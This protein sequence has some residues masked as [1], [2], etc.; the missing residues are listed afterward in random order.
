MNVKEFIFNTSGVEIY[1]IPNFLTPDECNH[2]CERIDQHS[3]RSEVAGAGN[4][5]T[6]YTSSRTSQSVS[7]SNS[8]PSIQPINTRIADEVGYPL[9]HGET[10]QGHVYQ[11]GQEFKDHNDFFVGDGFINHCLAS[12]QR[13]WT[14]MV[15]LNDVAAGGHTEFPEI[16]RSFA[17][18]KGTAV[19][20]KN[21]DG[22]GTEN[23]ATL[24]CGAPVLKGKKYIITKWF[25]ERIYSPSKDA[26]LAKEHH[27]GNS[28]QKKESTQNTSNELEAYVFDKKNNKVKIEYKDGIPNAMYQS[29]LD[30][31]PITKEGFAKMPIPKSLFYRILAFYHEGL[32]HS[33]PEFDPKNN[34][35]LRDFIS[36]QESYYPT[37]MIWLTDEMKTI[38]F[39]GLEDILINWANKQLLKTHCYGI[40]SYKRG[41]QLKKH[42]DG[43]Q[44]RIVSAILNIDQKVDEPWALQIDDHEGKEHEVYLEAG[45]MVLYESAVL[46]HG[47]VKPFKGD[48]FTNLFVHYIH[49]EE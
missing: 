34:D 23:A 4:Q 28:I 13:T 19:I 1:Q 47:R 26:Q 40:R 3:Q 7:F 12:G 45:E 32:E 2:L 46:S 17:P 16:G 33:K 41:A 48:Y 18:K 42:I 36:S 9:N 37:E 39:N 25:R 31:P 11:E 44:T 20:W 8:D 49:R 10:L 15:Y 27:K 24:H 35:D 30:I 43:F 29:N 6:T 5:S 38:I 14:V 22:Q 21:S